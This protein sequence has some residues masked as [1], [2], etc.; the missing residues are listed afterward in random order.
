MA[1]LMIKRGNEYVNAARKIGIYLD[2]TKIGT[3]SNG[4]TATFEIPAGTHKL[5]GKID[6]CA[7]REYEF[8]IGDNE[9][10]HLKLSG[11]PHSNNIM[12]AT[13]IIFVVHIILVVTTGF[14]YLGWLVLPSL[15]IMFYYLTFG[16]KDYLII[17]DHIIK[18]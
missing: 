5:H 14:S 11:I 13:A 3:L 9:T 17:K 12:L 2:E 1:T 15:L 8:T 18:P 16:R 10:K 7:S 6:W 4:S